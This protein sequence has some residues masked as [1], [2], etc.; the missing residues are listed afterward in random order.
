SLCRQPRFVDL[1]ERREFCPIGSVVELAITRQSRGE[2]GFAR[3]HRV[4]LSSNRE[5]RG[6]FTADLSCEQRE[7]ADR[8]HGH[9]AERAVIHAHGPPY[10]TRFRAAVKQGSLENNFLA[11]TCDFRNALWRVRF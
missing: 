11:E 7:I 1:P 8:V 4:A 2:A 9:R 5:R 3:T 10:K 6:A